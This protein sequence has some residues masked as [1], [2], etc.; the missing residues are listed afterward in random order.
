[1][2]KERFE[3]HCIRTNISDCKIKT[4]QIKTIQR[5]VFMR[6]AMRHNEFKRQRKMN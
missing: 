6:K 1:M 3:K 2:K 4:A 5:I